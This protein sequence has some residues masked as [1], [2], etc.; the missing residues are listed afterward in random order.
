[1]PET[2]KSAL[3]LAQRKS[4]TKKGVTL[5]TTYEEKPFHYEEPPE[6]AGNKF[7]PRVVK[8]LHN[9]LLRNQGKDEMYEKDKETREQRYKFLEMAN[10]SYVRPQRAPQVPYHSNNNKRRLRILKDLTPENE[11]ENNETRGKFSQAEENELTG[12][13]NKIETRRLKRNQTMHRRGEREKENSEYAK[14]T[15]RRL[16]EELVGSLPP[17]QQQ[18]PLSLLQER[19]FSPLLHQGSMPPPVP[20]HLSPHLRESSPQGRVTPSLQQGL[21]PLEVQRLLLLSEGGQSLL[22]ASLQRS[23]ILSGMQPPAPP[24]HERR[25]LSASE[26]QR[27]LSLSEREQY[28]LPPNVQRELTKYLYMQQSPSPS[29]QLSSPLPPAVNRMQAPQHPSRL[30]SQFFPHL[31]LENPLVARSK[32]Q[33][34]MKGLQSPAQST[35][36]PPGWNG[37]PAKNPAKNS[38]TRRVNAKPPKLP[39]EIMSYLANLKTKSGEKP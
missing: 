27:L 3:K 18:A 22:P 2:P 4:G 13:L 29:P 11:K 9:K 32:L 30:P 19:P 12:E 26:V 7:T 14:E 36:K 28:L 20:S 1:M 35:P 16:H 23:L 37:N 15:A 24:S 39:H 17:A 34:A 21:S 10:P 8:S 31:Q 33:A 6:Q 25:S 5:K 38:A